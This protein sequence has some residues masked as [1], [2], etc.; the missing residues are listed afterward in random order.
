MTTATADRA[1]TEEL[2][3]IA[4]RMRAEGAA[5]RAE[6]TFPAAPKLSIVVIVYK[7]SRQ[8]ENTL[9]SLSPAYQQ[10][11]SAD[12]YEVIVVENSSADP[13]GAERALAMGPNFRYYARPNIGASPVPGII[14][15]V[16]STRAPI[17]GLVIDGARM[18]T[19]RVVR[20]ALD[21]F[22]ITDH[23]MVNVPGYH[24]GTDEQHSNPAHDE[25][26]E[27]AM[28]DAVR[29]QEDGYRLFVISSY[30]RGRH[31][32]GYLMPVME[33]NC[34]FCA[35]ADYESIGGADIRFDMPGGGMVNL[36]LYRQ[37]AMLPHVEL[38]ALPGEG[39][40]HQYHGGVTTTADEGREDMLHAFREQYRELRGTNYRMVEREPRLLGAVTGWATP[41][42]QFSAME[43][44]RIYEL[45]GWDSWT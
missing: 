32:H 11:V 10:G 24:L 30:F 16:E 25:A 7:M 15:G 35:R 36:D 38:F 39:T 44:M 6:A 5:A 37:L 27:Q 8:A 41:M 1:S 40:F 9:Y 17:L 29:W 18:V 14:F 31:Q 43:R 4:E 45:L 34:L 13:L 3:A 42:L 23:A 19:P 26:A 21:A 20:Y 22:A 28:L 2:L 33:S 12:D